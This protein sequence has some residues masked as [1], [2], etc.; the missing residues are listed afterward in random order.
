[1]EMGYQQGRKWREKKRG[2]GTRPCSYQFNWW[3]EEKKAAKR[4]EM[5]SQRRIWKTRKIFS[6]ESKRKAFRKMVIH[7]VKFCWG[8]RC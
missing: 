7:Y 5:N 3:V 1:M 6:A 4:S 8:L 2:P